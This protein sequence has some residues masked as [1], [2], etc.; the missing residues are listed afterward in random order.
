[1]PRVPRLILLSLAGAI[2]LLVAAVLVVTLV[3]DPNRYRAPIEKAVRDASGRD[4]DLEGDIEIAWV[5]WLALETG[6]AQLGNPAGFDGPP[7]LGWDSARVGVRLWPLIQGDLVV[8]RVSFDGLRASLHVDKA[9]RAN[10]QGFGTQR[11]AGDARAPFIPRNAGLEL[12]NAALEYVDERTGTRAGITDW[13]LDIGAY[14]S[15]KPVAV[16]TAFRYRGL[17]VEF[18][19]EALLLDLDKRRITAPEWSLRIGDAQATGSLRSGDGLQGLSGELRMRAPS[20]RELLGGLGADVPRTRDTAAIGAID[21]KATWQADDGAVRVQPIAI[22]LD[23]TSITGQLAR[24]GKDPMWTFELRGDRIDL[25][26]YL[27]PDDAEGKPF[28]LPTAALKAANVRGTLRFDAARVAGVD[29]KDVILRVE[30]DEPAS[31]GEPST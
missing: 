22:K 11:G 12:R 27:E 23:D 13:S 24:A 4:F 18:E 29:A 14:D 19:E 10:W 28:E 17:P 30:T 8:D 31:A 6:K 15:G 5:P 9:G 25:D 2:F 3:V 16:E 21:L 20:L 1:M 26:R 7:L